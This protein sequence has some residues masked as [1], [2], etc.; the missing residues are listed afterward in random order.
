[1]QDAPPANNRLRRRPV[2]ESIVPCAIRIRRQVWARQLRCL[3]RSSRSSQSA[4]AI[5]TKPIPGLANQRSC[6]ARMTPADKDRDTGIRRSDLKSGQRRGG[7]TMTKLPN[8]T[9]RFVLAA[10]C[11][12]LGVLSTTESFANLNSIVCRAIRRGCNSDCNA[13]D[14]SQ[15]CYQRCLLNYQ[16][17]AAGVATKK[18]QTPPPPCSGIH[19]TLRPTHPPTTVGPTTPPPRPV[20]PVN[21][22]GV[23]NPNKPTTGNEPVIQLQKNDSGGSGGQGHGHH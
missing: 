18:Q 21:P 16:D 10:I 7:S 4:S 14:Q 17:C 15:A 19:C 1:M 3:A 6:S 8:N 20:K 12:L 9:N 2:R 23:S 5:L 11:C 13:G 22:V